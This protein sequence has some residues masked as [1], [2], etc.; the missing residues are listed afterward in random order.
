M[1]KTA[2]IIGAGPAGLTAAYELLDKTD[3]KPVILEQTDFVGGISATRCHNGNRMD[4]GG[5]RF[6]SKSKIVTD[7]WEKFLP[8]QGKPSFDDVL[9]N[10]QTTFSEKNNAPDPKNEDL[11]MLYRPRVS[12][13]YYAGAFFD[14]PV[15]LNFKT[16]RNLGVWRMLKIACSYMLSVV[17]K[18]KENSLEDFFINR[19]G[20]ELEEKRKELSNYITKKEYQKKLQKGFVRFWGKMP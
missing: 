19:F 8:L 12:R 20:Q 5:H 15:K 11:V 1:A 17:C 13:I 7:W 3:I 4:M 9:F 14:Y 10:R 16:M 6:F 2:L 18:R